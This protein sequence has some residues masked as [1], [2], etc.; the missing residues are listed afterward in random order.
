VDGAEEPDEAAGLLGD[1]LFVELAPVDGPA[2][3][4]ISLGQL[5]RV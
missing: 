1:S 2:C 3:G 5:E 4:A